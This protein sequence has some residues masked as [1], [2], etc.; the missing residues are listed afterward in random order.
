MTKMLTLSKYYLDIDSLDPL[1]YSAASSDELAAMISGP[2]A[3]SVITITAVAEGI[4]QITVTAADP[5]APCL[6]PCRTA[7][8]RGNGHPDAG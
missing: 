1:T 5:H 8:V 6:G 2:D 7:D 3:N 4:A